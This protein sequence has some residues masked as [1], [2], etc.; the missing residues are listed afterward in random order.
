MSR[1]G[2]RRRSTWDLPNLEP[3]KLRILTIQVLPVA[4]DERDEEV[5]LLTDRLGLPEVGFGIDGDSKAG[6][7]E[8]VRSSGSAWFLIAQ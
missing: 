1:Y 5:V 6:H 4:S 2:V 8:R 3:D 7:G